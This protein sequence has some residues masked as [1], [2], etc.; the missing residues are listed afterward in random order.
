MAETRREWSPLM[1][2]LG[3]NGSGAVS[4][5]D[6]R[7]AIYTLLP[8][9]SLIYIAS[10]DESA[11]TLGSTDWTKASGTTTSVLLDAFTMPTDNRLL[12]SGTPD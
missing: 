5:T 12:Y 6:I 11:T 2:L 9:L 4:A 3:T 7:D 8:N 1:T 10:G